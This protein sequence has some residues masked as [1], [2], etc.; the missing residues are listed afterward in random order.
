MAKERT[1]VR[2]QTQIRLMS[3]QGYSIRAI[4]RTLK[5]SRKTVRRILG[6]A[7][8][9]SSELP[10]WIGAVDWE[11]VR[12]EIYGKGTTVKQIQRE[13]APDIAYV[14]FWRAFREK[15]GCQA[16]PDQVT[17]R[18]DH[19]PAEKAQ[20]DFC[21]GVFIT[22]PVTGNKTLT[23]FFLG[24]LPF[25]S[26]TFGEF[27]LDQKLSTF[28]GVQSR[29]FAY[30]GGITPYV[31]VDNLKSGVNKADLY[32]PD[33]NPTYCDFANHMGFAV[34]PARPRKP[35]DKG[36]GE[37]HIGVVQRG[38][39]QEVRNRVFYSLHEL[40]QTLRD[41]LQRLNHEVM[42]DYGVS[43][44][45]RFEEEQKQLKSLP[46]SPFELSEWRQA[47][48]HPDCH[49]QVEKN[50]YSVPFV[51]VGQKVRVRLTEKIVEVF[52]ED[53]QPLTAHTRLR[54]IGQFSTYDFHYPEKKLSVA[55]FE[56]RHAQHQAKQLGPHV[57]QLVDQLFSGSHP[58]R[59]LRRVQGILRLAKRYPITAEALDHA[60]QRAL[61]FNKTRLAYIKD[62][63]RYFVAHGHRPTLLTPKRK[64]DTV[65]LH[66][67]AASSGADPELSSASEEE[68]LL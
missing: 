8:V 32:D 45:Q 3:E 39:F 34:L 28:I 59:H 62:C 33:V 14:K 5:L 52:S 55:R 46:P 58:L 13:V 56:V 22:D 68:E 51:Y 10:E 53:S 21:D 26:Y 4:A 65:H 66:Q 18:L 50:F 17:I 31:V 15:L 54:G 61:T 36:S 41:Y 60:C 25:S 20:I 12:Q 43:R 35:R 64:P 37:T 11:Y 1:S 19:K 44:S 2:M 38:F 63:A 29:M 47:K 27:V 49:I 42:K 7:V 9:Q 40:N 23:Q 24:V 57:E 16:S 30:F 67:Y 48:V 6:I